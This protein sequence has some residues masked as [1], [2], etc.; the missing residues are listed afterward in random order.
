MK[1]KQLT[2]SQSMMRNQN[3]R[4][5]GRYSQILA[6]LKVLLKELADLES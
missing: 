2:R 5:K 3:A 1:K 4:K 6:E